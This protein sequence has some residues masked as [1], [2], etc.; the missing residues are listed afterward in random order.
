MKEVGLAWIQDEVCMWDGYMREAGG[1]GMGTE[2]E[3]VVGSKGKLTGTVCS[4]IDTV[5]TT[6]GD[7][8]LGFYHTWN[9]RQCQHH[10]HNTQTCHSRPFHCFHC[11]QTCCSETRVTEQLIF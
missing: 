11:C 5:S 9:H 8:N 4:S 6:M 2:T 7:S 1:C 3:K 10:A